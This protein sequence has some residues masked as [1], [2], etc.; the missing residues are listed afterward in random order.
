VAGELPA[1]RGLFNWRLP[2]DSLTVMSSGPVDTTIGTLPQSGARM[3]A[4]LLDQVRSARRRSLVAVCLQCLTIVG[5]GFI[6]GIVAALFL[7]ALFGEVFTLLWNVSRLRVEVIIVA[8]AVGICCV[9]YLPWLAW[10]VLRPERLVLRQLR[11]RD[12]SS[13]EEAR[14]SDI[15]EEM[16]VA[17]GIRLPMLGVID[18]RAPNG[19]IL[20]SPRV[21]QIVVTT[22]LLE[23]LERDE[24]EAVVGHLVARAIG[25]DLRFASVLAGNVAALGYAMQTPALVPAVLLCYYPAIFWSRRVSRGRV[26]LAD[27]VGVTLMRDPQA[28][29]DALEKIYKDPSEISSLPEDMA[30]LAFVDPHYPATMTGPAQLRV[31]PWSDDKGSPLHP[32]IKQ[33]VER[34]APLAA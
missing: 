6:V 1:G 34:L 15:L 12:P 8:I 26:Q 17:A 28:L 25:G 13:A 20:G 24:L 14:L 2:A 23:I 31:R 32:P 33:R 11:A 3:P 16:A 7:G 29:I 21:P 18:D 30:M 4:D 19:F 22:G 5:V 27:H 9:I 10:C